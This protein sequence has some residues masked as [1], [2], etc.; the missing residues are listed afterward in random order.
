M[1]WKI[2]K[3]KLKESKTFKPLLELKKVKA[4]F[5]RKVIFKNNFVYP[6]VSKTTITKA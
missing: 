2:G 5:E 1:L 6:F 4:I 3:F